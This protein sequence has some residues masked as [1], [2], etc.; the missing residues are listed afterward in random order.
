MGGFGGF[1]R[2]YRRGYKYFI[3]NKIIYNYFLSE[4]MQ[5]FTVIKKVEG[6]KKYKLWWGRWGGLLSSYL[7]QVFVFFEELDGGG[8]SVR[9]RNTLHVVGGRQF[10]SQARFTGRENISKI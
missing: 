3:K 10:L 8:G 1:Y 4:R 6:P 5:R 2:F 9:R 7:A